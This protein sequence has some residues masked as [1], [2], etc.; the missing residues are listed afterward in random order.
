MP[1]SYHSTRGIVFRQTRYSDTSLVVKILTEELGL[2]SYIVKGAR[3]PKARIKAGMFQPLTLLD[4]VVSQNEKKD[5]NHIKEARLA[6]SYQNIH[7]DIRKSSILLFIDELLVKSIQE[8]SAN[9]E[10]F[11]YIYDHLLFLD[12]VPDVPG[13]FHLLFALHLSKYL[14][15]F[16]QGEYMGPDGIFDL[17]EG[18]FSRQ[19]LLFGEYCISGVNCRHFSELIDTAPKDAHQ[20]QVPPAARQDLLEILL[21]YYHLHLPLQGSFK[22][23]II[24][25]EVLQK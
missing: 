19:G 3:G 10:L 25:H 6:H 9:K 18:H 5:L 14:G 12:R 20:L 22:S 2:R 16:P 13:G 17:E 4:L 21:R 8:E 15:F 7:K 23:H 11:E 1:P 24:L